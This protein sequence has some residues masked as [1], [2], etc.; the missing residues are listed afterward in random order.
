MIKEAKDRRWMRL[1]EKAPRWALTVPF[2]AVT[3]VLLILSSFGAG[4][5]EARLSPLLI[6]SVTAFLGRDLALFNFFNLGERRKRVD[7]LVILWLLILY[8]LIPGIFRLL[9]AKT[10]AALFWP[11][12]DYALLSCAAALCQLFAAWRM[13]VARWKNKHSII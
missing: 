13:T 8:G 7:M 3:A 5:N 2:V 9:K 11:H 1:M 6:I 12:M 4:E 10:V